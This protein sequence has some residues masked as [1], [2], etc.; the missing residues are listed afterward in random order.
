ML[1]PIRSFFTFLLLLTGSLAASAQYADRGTGKLKPYI[2]WFDWNGFTVANGATKTFTTH[3][4]I[5]I[6]V[7]ISNVSGTGLTPDVMNTWSG[8][9]LHNLYEFSDPAMRPSLHSRASS[10]NTGFDMEVTAERNGV[11]IPFTLVAADAEASENVEITHFTSSG[12]PWQAVEY[13]SNRSGMPN[14][15]SGC[16]TTAIRIA[17]TYGGSPGSGQNPLMATY[18][19]G[20]A[21]L[22]VN[23]LLER[24]AG[25]VGGMAVT[26]GL[27]APID[28]GDL[29]SPYPAAQHAVAYAATSGCNL[30]APG[31][32]LH[33]QSQLHIGTAMADPDA[34]QGTDDNLV[35]ADEDGI[36]VFPA[37]NGST[38][39][40]AL[41]L[42]VTNQTGATAYASGWMDW[43]NDGAFSAAES[44]VVPV[45][46]GATSVAFSWAGLPYSLADGPSAPCAFRFRIAATRAEVE[47]PTGFAASGEVEDYFEQL[48]QTCNIT[49]VSA[50]TDIVICQG[51]NA[52]LAASGASTYLWAANAS[53]SA[54]NIP[55]PVANPGATVDYFLY[56][57]HANGC[58]SRDTVNVRVDPLPQLAVTP[59]RHTVCQGA[60]VT[61]TASGADVVTWSDYTGATVGTGNVLTVTPQLTGPYTAVLRENHCGQSATITLPV[62]L[63]LRPVISVT[64]RNSRI[65]AGTAVT[66]DAAGGETIVWEDA[67]GNV[68]GNGPRL[69][70]QP[71]ATA[72][73]KVQVTNS[74]CAMSETFDLLVTV[75]S[76]G[77]MKVTPSEGFACKGGKVEFVA[78]GADEAVW[79][80]ADFTV[81]GTGDRL[82]ADVTASTAYHVTMRD[83]VCGLERRETLPVNMRPDPQVR[84]TKSNDVDCMNGSALL[85]VSG[86]NEYTWSAGP[87]VTDP[88]LPVQQVSPPATHK[89]YV[90][91]RDMY[92]CGGVDSVTVG[93]SWTGPRPHFQLP[94]AFT[95]NGDGVNDCFRLKTTGPATRFELLVFDRWGNVVFKTNKTDHCWDGTYKNVPLD[96]GT[97]VYLL[98]IESE[99]G[100]VERKGTVTLLR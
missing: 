31:P 79:E 53:L 30:A 71:A 81:I 24:S 88:T 22:R 44:I 33:P 8:A 10:V 37:Y 3:D 46:A 36:A 52:R 63:T 40:Y 9:V 74:I 26:F 95:P 58:H 65:C 19:D 100:P 4:G 55:D 6:T 68:I 93:V 56:A 70:V 85:M 42:A 91:F 7:R 41:N 99:C 64:P 54:V 21:P 57:E 47:S 66:F 29:P 94:N 60:P 72:N 38:G 50:G 82:V 18:S 15:I 48:L 92:G 62:S 2:W 5:L 32:S 51:R 20:S 13:F 12:A 77:D 25:L 80:A 73:Y 34:V 61:F 45:P 89:Y 1:I 97:F 83:L 23:T 87:G 14:P 90:A 59:D 27:L 96:I 69:Q 39:A 28:R 98:R 84:I 11:A 35:G 86:A 49:K 75:R 16:N 17:S 76:P 78:Q 43:D 67:Q